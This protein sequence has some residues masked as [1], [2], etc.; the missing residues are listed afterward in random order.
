MV[1]VMDMPCFLS[2]SWRHEMSTAILQDEV[3]S[4]QEQIVS[5]HR[6]IVRNQMYLDKVVTNQEAL[7]TTQG[8]LTVNHQ[9][10]ENVLSI[11]VSMVTIQDAIMANQ[12]AIIGDMVKLDQ[13]LSRQRTIITNRSNSEKNP[14]DQQETRLTKKAALAR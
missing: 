8:S 9:A 10:F 14:I 2:Y 7:L 13:L 6:R 5:N 1:G 3:V 11:Q 12:E 4:N